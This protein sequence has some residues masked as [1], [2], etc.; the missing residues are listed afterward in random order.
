MG[1]L[2]ASWRAACDP[3]GHANESPFLQESN[4]AANSDRGNRVDGLGNGDRI[5]S[6]R[7]ALVPETEFDQLSIATHLVLQPERT[8][9]RPQSY[10]W[11]PDD[12]LRSKWPQDGHESYE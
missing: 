7:V 8:A 9:S 4:D 11:K 3:R 6:G 2:P 1:Q 12:V 5:L 10:Q